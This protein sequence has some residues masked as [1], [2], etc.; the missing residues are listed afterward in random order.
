MVDISDVMRA[1]TGGAAAFNPHADSHRFPVPFRLLLNGAPESGKTACLLSIILMFN[2]EDKLATF[3]SSNIYIVSKTAD[4]AVYDALKE[5]CPQICF[6][7]PD[8]EWC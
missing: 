4:Q 7:S 2:P 5:L 1:S 6:L 3:L 8:N